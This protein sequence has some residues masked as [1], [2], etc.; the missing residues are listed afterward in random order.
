[1]QIILKQPLQKENNEIEI[2]DFN[3][4]IYIVKIQTQEN[5]DVWKVV[6]E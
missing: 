6:K 5:V 1:L 4:G 2:S 3:S